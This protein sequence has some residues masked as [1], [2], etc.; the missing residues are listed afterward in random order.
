MP[1]PRPTSNRRTPYIFINGSPCI[2]CTWCYN[3]VK[4]W[5][6]VLGRHKGKDQAVAWD[7]R[8]VLIGRM[9]DRRTY[10]WHHGD[11]IQQF[12]DFDVPSVQKAPACMECFNLWDLTRKKFKGEGKKVELGPLVVHYDTVFYDLSVQEPRPEHSIIVP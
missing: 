2:E 11:Q 9:Q 8:A 12:R 10:T 6:L 1:S 7:H 5:D 3:L 4:L